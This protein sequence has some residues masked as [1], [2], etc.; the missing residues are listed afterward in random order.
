MSDTLVIQSHRLPLPYPWLETCLD[1]VR[2]WSQLNQYDYRFLAD[3]LFTAVPE[4]LMLKTAGQTV[5]ATDLAR[6]LVLQ[7]AMQ[8]GYDT[9]VWL[10]ADF[11]IFNA[12]AFNLPDAPC[13]LGREVWVQENDAG[14]LKVY[15]KV[16]N[17]FL[18]FR[19]GNSFL[20]FYTD[21]ARQLLSENQGS[22][23]PQFIGPKLLTALHNV[24]MLPV[25]ETA[26]MFSPLLVQDILQG[27]GAA[28]DLFVKHSPHPVAGAN[29]CV[30]SR[31]KGD[32]S[33]REMQQLI[34][35]L[36]AGSLKF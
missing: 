12:D 16:H 18:M 4:E 1:S 24:A 27:Q 36:L 3:E 10:D 28:Y 33:D 35:T 14:K 9:V 17:A 8:E 7:A 15:K 23:P 21:T 13:A 5:I 34:D 19:E 11:L 26:G 29:L 22:M 20:D 2:N 32:V 6:L 31:Q 30:S 25:M